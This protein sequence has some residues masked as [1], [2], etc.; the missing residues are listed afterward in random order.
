M[1]TIFTLIATAILL[2]NYAKA[3]ETMYMYKLG[4]ITDSAVI[5]NIDSILFN[6]A[7][8]KAM[9]ADYDGNLYHT[10]TIGTQEWFRENLKTTKLND[11]T[12]IPKVQ[13]NA[14]WA[15]L[16]TPGYSVYNDVFLTTS[17]GIHYNWYAV[18]TYKLCPTGWHTATFDEWET[19]NNFLG[20]SD[21]SGG[22]MKSVSGGPWYEGWDG[23]NT[24]NDNS[25]DFFGVA[26]GT[27]GIDGA[28]NDWGWA[29]RFWTETEDPA[30]PTKA[31]FK[32]LHSTTA[33][34]WQGS[35]LKTAGYSVRCIKD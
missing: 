2:V 23:P 10:I 29:S 13:D 24:G 26:A 32:M 5:S 35:E 14:P 15:A 11:G 1:R 4:Y 9:I 17:Y 31:R 18:E 12:D 19:L 27:R 33:N 6:R 34:L 7:P 3:Q 22:K 21:V 28:F 20:G 16:T 30:D 8:G 25:S